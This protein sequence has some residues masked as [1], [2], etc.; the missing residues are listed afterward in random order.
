MPE[1][2]IC[3][4]CQTRS[5]G[6]SSLRAISALGVLPSQ[7]S[8]IAIESWCARCRSSLVAS[9]HSI[10][11]DGAWCVGSAKRVLTAR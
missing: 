5:G 1:S 11:T 10:R 9:C 3:E 2:A 8:R 7:Y 4:S 6:I